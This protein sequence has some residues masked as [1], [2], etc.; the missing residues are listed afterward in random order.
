MKSW[1]WTGCH[2]LPQPFSDKPT[3]LIKTCVF[4]TGCRGFITVCHAQPKSRSCQVSTYC[5]F[6]PLLLPRHP[7]KSDKIGYC[8]KPISICSWALSE[9]Y[10]C[11]TY[12]AD[13]ALSLFVYF[14][15]QGWDGRGFQLE[16]ITHA[17]RKGLLTPFPEHNNDDRWATHNLW[18]P[19]PGSSGTNMSNV[20]FLWCSVINFYMSPTLCRCCYCVITFWMMLNSHTRRHCTSF[21]AVSNPSFWHWNAAA[22]TASSTQAIISEP[23]C[24]SSF[25]EAVEGCIVHYRSVRKLPPYHHFAK[26]EYDECQL[27]PA[28]TKFLHPVVECRIDNHHCNCKPQQ[29]HRCAETQCDTHLLKNLG[30]VQSDIQRWNVALST[31]IPNLPKLECMTCLLPNVV[32]RIDRFHSVRRLSQ[33]HHFREAQ[34]A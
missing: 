10:P 13:T 2:G 18:R 25:H 22:R 20:A 26:V 28:H 23:E 19:P 34:Y 31:A 24:I 8:K 30:V 6:W 33:S 21:L 27:R 16:I 7:R 12:F 3:F 1:F 32:G 29:H 17:A 15:P 14:D 4:V 11:G 5:V 9:K